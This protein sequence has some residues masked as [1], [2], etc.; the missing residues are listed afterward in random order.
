MK[1]LR[2]P[3]LGVNF[4]SSYIKNSIYYS[5]SNLNFRVIYVATDKFM[6]SK[7]IINGQLK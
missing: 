5:I 6:K 7:N 2:T 3:S 4:T 1:I